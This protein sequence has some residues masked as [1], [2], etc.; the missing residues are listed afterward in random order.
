MGLFGK[1]KCPRCDSTK[2][3]VLKKP[4]WLETGLK[5][6][7][8]AEWLHPTKNLNVCRECGFSWEDR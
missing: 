2:L 3:K 1:K 7:I 4:N 6:R 5:G 8:I